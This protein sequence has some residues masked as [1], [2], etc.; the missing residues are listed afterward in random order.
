MLKFFR[1][2]RQKMLTENKFSKYLVLLF[3]MLIISTAAQAQNLVIK[4]GWMVNVKEGTA[5]EN[6]GITIVA[7]KIYEIGNPSMEFPI[8]RLEDQDYLLP[9]LI[10]LHSHYHVRYDGV[11]KT[12]TVVTPKLFLANGVTT[13]FTAGDPNPELILELKHKINRHE[14]IGP[15]ILN[16]GPYFGTANSEWNQDY[17]KEEI[18]NIVDEWAA[19]GAQGFKAK[20]ISY[21]HLKYLI[22]RAHSYGLTVTSHLGY[23]VDSKDAIKLGIDRVEHFLGGEMLLGESHPYV[24]IANLDMERDSE[25]IDDAMDLFIEHGVYLNATIGT[26]G[27]WSRTD[28]E[29]FEYWS[30]EYKYLTPFT[31]DYIK[32]TDTLQQNTQPTIAMVY[33]NKKLLL[34]K[35]FDKGGRV[36]L[37]TDRPFYLDLNLGNYINGFFVHREMEVMTEAGI[38]NADV[39]KIATLNSAEAIGWGDR[40]GSIE[41]SKLADFMVIKGNP[42]DDIQNTRTVH[43]VIKGGIVFDSEEVLKQA[44]GKLGPVSETE[45]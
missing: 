19:K 23:G 36:T 42:L 29:A 28:D 41:V 20:G 38:S 12:D 40:I 17:T 6:P 43:T 14:V 16:S 7:G 44:E 13:T 10:D 33:E 27:G 31:A 11:T 35:Y 3:S 39:L 32:R 8:L 37:G 26:Y 18:Y 30:D 2:I 22:E 4:G 5:I 25:R 9:G 34:K 45:W 1:I 21:N 24:E 15:R